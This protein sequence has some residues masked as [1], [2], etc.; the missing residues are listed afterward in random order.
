MMPYAV[1]LIPSS[2]TTGRISASMPR[3][4][5]EY[6]ICSSRTG[7]TAFAR[8]IVSGPTSDRPRYRTYPASIISAMA[9]TVSSIGTCGSSRAGWYRSTWS[10]PSRVSE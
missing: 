7:Y 9:P 4:I 6:S 1:T 2:R 8:R 3:L 10:V 5:S